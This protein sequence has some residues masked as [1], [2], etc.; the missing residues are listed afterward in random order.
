MSTN[1]TKN[2]GPSPALGSGLLLAMLLQAAGWL[3][4]LAVLAVLQLAGGSGGYF[5]AKSYARLQSN[6]DVLRSAAVRRENEAS[7]S[8]H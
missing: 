6:I 4:K 8:I 7:M 1:A 3:Q 2:S 5:S